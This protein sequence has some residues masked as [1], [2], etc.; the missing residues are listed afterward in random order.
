M[1]VQLTRQNVSAQPKR[2][3]GDRLKVLFL[4]PPVRLIAAPRIPPMG[5]L[6]MAAILEHEGIDVEIL[7]LNVLRLPIDQV[8]VEIR[9]R[10]FD[11]IG[12]GGMTTVY[13]YIKLLSLKIKAEFPHVPIIGGGSACSASPDTV[14]TKT[15]VDVVCI[16]EGEPI[17]ADLVRRLAAQQSISDI[18]GIGYFGSD[19]KVVKTSTRGRYE[20]WPEGL[21]PAHHLVDM[22]VY[23]RNNA[24]KYTNVPGMLNRIKELGLDPDKAKRPIH[25]FSKRGCPFPC[26]FCYR[27]FGRKVVY[28]SVDH[29]LDYMTMLMEKYDTQ[30]FVFGDELFNVNE[31]WVASFCEGVKKRGMKV[32]LSTSNGLRANCCTEESLRTMYDVG[33]YRVGIGI[34]SFHEPSLVAMKK[35]QTAVQIKEAIRLI[36]KVG[37]ELNEGGMLF[38]YET[39]NWDAMR[40]NVDA[41]TELGWFMTGFSI[42]CPYPG[43]YLY[44]KAIASGAITEE[45]P[46]LLELADRDVADR[47]IN[48]S[49]LP[50]EELQRIIEWGTDQLAI[51]EVR[52]KYP[53]L[54]RFLDVAQPLGRRISK[55]VDVLLALWKVKKG[56]VIAA[57]VARG[58]GLP[59]RRKKSYVQVQLAQD[60]MNIVDKQGLNGH[61]LEDR[62]GDRV[63]LHE[64]LSA[65]SSFADAR[66]APLPFLTL[67]PEVISIPTAV[68]THAD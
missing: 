21:F 4:Y 26:T 66:P 64:A 20:G 36:R 46:W 68:G 48:M 49:G 35:Q 13:Y 53:L 52:Q 29:V 47:I 6:Y 18:P 28:D 43:T 50:T 32:L 61:R 30:H 45:E 55:K 3:A 37:L 62:T 34:E 2:A 31:G 54:A 11:V 60:G 40:S 14:L 19:G 27:N 8:M 57:D 10:Q 56:A 67:Q 17:I 22:E 24:V 16:G 1:L 44:D 58:R 7:D 51:N 23:I 65:L 12:M 38:G 42:P 5:F 63:L 25:I 15:G 41:L 39:D 59:K 33:F 9:K